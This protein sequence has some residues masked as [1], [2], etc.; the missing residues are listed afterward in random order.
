M[1]LIAI[2]GRPNVGKSD[3]FNR[4]TKGS[5]AFLTI[6]PGLPA[7]KLWPAGPGGEVH[8][9]VVDTG[10]FISEDASL[11]EAKPKRA[12]V[13]ALDEATSSSLFWM[14]KAE[15]I[16]KTISS[17]TSCV[18]CQSPSSTPSIRLTARAEKKH[19]RILRTRAGQA[20]PPSVQRTALGS[21]SS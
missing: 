14:R 2:V 10:G 4:I 8:S 18:V 6:C 12:G 20:L 5:R 17:P 21:E 1:A 9:T 15:C 3:L 7:T 11:I 13:G 16:R 19:S